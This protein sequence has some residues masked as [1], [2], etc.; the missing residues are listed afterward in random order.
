M[1][2]MQLAETFQAAG[3]AMI[4]SRNSQRVAM[5]RVRVLGCLLVLLV[6]LPGAARAEDATIGVAIN[7]VATPFSGNRI[8]APHDVSELTFQVAP[9]TL[10]VRYKLEGID[11]AWQQQPGEMNFI[12]RFIKMNGDQTLQVFFP[13]IGDS[14]GWKGSVEGSDFVSRREIVIVPPEAEYVSIALSSSGPPNAIGIFAARG[15][16][17]NPLEDDARRFLVDS[18]GFGQA[19]PLWTK[20]GTHPSMASAT[21]LDEDSGRS[22]LLYIIDDDLIAHADWATGLYSLPKVVPGERLEVR[23]EEAYSVGLGGPFSIDYERLPPGAYEFVVEELEV[24]GVPAGAS[25][26]VFVEVPRA[27]WQRWW[28]WLVCTTGAS[29]LAYLWGRHLIRRRINRHLRHAQLIADERLRIARDLHDDLGT[30]L[31][32]ISLLGAHA[33]SNIPDPEARATFRQITGMSG[34]LISAL[35]E[36]VW[37][38]NSNNNHLESLVD[39]LCRLVAELCRL[40]EIRCRID[41]MPV[42]EDRP[43]SHE[44]RHNFSLSVK[45]AVNNALRHSQATEIRMKIWMENQ[46]LRISVTDNGIGLRDDDMGSGSGL[47]SI[48]QR[49]ASIRGNCSIEPVGSGGLQVLLTA[50]VK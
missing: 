17:V 33:E 27:Y 4:H 35:S 28:F 23:W 36:T 7:Q 2:G 22:P 39:F 25:A 5:M 29:A 3:P 49:M 30:R 42:T 20:S 32:H 38:L 10:R 19:N 6:H 9:R 26:S 50:P 44:F 48:T 12:V 18:R 47:A 16:T 41:A 31:S 45:E 8:S 1:A 37:M 40:A 46:I 14:A 34:E 21:G 13:A 24:N 15:I 43:V 11:R